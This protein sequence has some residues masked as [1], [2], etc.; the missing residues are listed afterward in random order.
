M[1]LYQDS[2]LQSSEVISWAGVIAGPESPNRTGVSMATTS[3]WI[4][5]LIQISRYIISPKLSTYELRVPDSSVNS[6]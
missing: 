4:Q 3:L 6:R 5:S 2:Y 1:V